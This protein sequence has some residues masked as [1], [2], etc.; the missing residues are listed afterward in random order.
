M[1]WTTGDGTKATPFVWVSVIGVAGTL[2]REPKARFDDP[3][4]FGRDWREEGVRPQSLRRRPV[5][6]RVGGQ[7]KAGGQTGRRTCVEYL[8]GFF[9]RQ[10]AVL[11]FAFLPFGLLRF[12][13]SLV[14]VV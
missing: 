6:E 8:E 14:L 2:L 9:V 7:R 10:R 1:G 4:V 13:L 3:Q 11:R 5:T 12:Y